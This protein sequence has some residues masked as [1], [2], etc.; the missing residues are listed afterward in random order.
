[1]VSINHFR[2]A[3]HNI[4]IVFEDSEINSLALIDSFQPFKVDKTDEDLLFQLTVDDN[5]QPVPK[6][7]RHRIR[8]FDSGNGDTIVDR[9]DDGGYQYIIKDING[10]GCCLLITD[11]D[12]YN[13]RCALNGN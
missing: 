6:E 9:L 3:E 2:I 4:R 13:C 7:R 11:K 12:F 1:M 5:L 8:A 10:R